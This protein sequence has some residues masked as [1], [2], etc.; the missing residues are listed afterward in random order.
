MGLETRAR[1]FWLDGKEIRLVS[2]AMHYFRV[3]PEYWKHRMLTMK[4]AGLN[5]L[6]T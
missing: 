6:E 4:A 3:M 5:C 1:A 2:G